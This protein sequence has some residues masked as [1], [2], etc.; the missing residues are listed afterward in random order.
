MGPSHLRSQIKVCGAA[1]LLLRCPAGSVVLRPE[2]GS[3]RPPFVVL[4]V[5]LC[6]INELKMVLHVGISVAFFTAS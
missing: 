6:Y 2:I 3:A 4:V 1:L 5:S